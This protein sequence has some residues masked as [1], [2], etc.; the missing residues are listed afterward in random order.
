VRSHNQG[1]RRYRARASANQSI[2]DAMVT[3]GGGA[4]RDNIANS[5][6]S[7][8]ASSRPPYGWVERRGR[9]N[10]NSEF[11]RWKR[12]AGRQETEVKLQLI[13]AWL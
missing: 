5:N 3:G 6:G 10:R 1:R 9:S 13:D 11:R 7:A 4:Y 12:D 8:G 2:T